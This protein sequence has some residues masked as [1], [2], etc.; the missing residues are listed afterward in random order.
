MTDMEKNRVNHGFNKLIFWSLNSNFRIVLYFLLKLRIIPEMTSGCI[1]KV[2]II[3]K[4]VI[5]F[6]LRHSK[7]QRF[8]PHCNCRIDINCSGKYHAGMLKYVII[9]SII[10]LSTSLALRARTIKVSLSLFFFLLM[11]VSP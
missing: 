11:C 8:L 6:F 10:N 7:G 9:I 4:Q 1:S 2:Q 3:S 5:F